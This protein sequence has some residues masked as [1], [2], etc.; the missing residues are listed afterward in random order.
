MRRAQM[1]THLDSR[2]VV[3]TG[4]FRLGRLAALA[5]AG[6]KRGEFYLRRRG[7]ACRLGSDAGAQIGRHV[8]LWFD[9]AE[10]YQARPIVERQRMWRRGLGKTWKCNGCNRGGDDD[11]PHG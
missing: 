8:E 9:V 7:L 4:R 1:H 11:A 2:V 10:K 6:S 5:V 3:E